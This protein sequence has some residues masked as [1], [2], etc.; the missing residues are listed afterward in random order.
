MSFLDHHL[1]S[2]NS[3]IGSSIA[4]LDSVLYDRIF[5]VPYDPVKLALRDVLLVS[6]LA[7]ATPAEVH[8]SAELYAVVRRRL[9]GFRI[10]LDVLVAPHF[11]I[12][13]KSTLLTEGKELS[14]DSRETFLN[15]LRPADRKLV[16]QVEELSS[17]RRFFHWDLEFPELFFAPRAGVLD[18]GGQSD[19]SQGIERK[20]TGEAG[21][22]A[23]VGNPP[24]VRQETIKLDK[25]YL[26]SAFA[27]TFD[28]AIDPLAIAASEKDQLTVIPGDFK[29]AFDGQLEFHPKQKRFLLLYNNKYDRGLAPGQHHPRTRFSISHELGHFYLDRHNSYLR[30]TR[31]K[32]G[33]RSEFA[34]NTLVEREADSFASGLLMP[35]LLMD[36][37]VNQCELSLDRIEELARTFQTSL[38]STALRAV[39]LSDYPCAVVGIRNGAVAWVSRSEA[40]IKN[41]F[42]PPR[43]GYFTSPVAIQQWQAF[44]MGV[45][46]R[47]K[48]PVYAHHWFET[49][50]SAELA[51]ISVTE[52]YLPVGSMSTLVVLLT[53]PEDELARITDYDD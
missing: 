20:P 41:R 22:D 32:H 8:Q 50:E 39:A 42:Y 48:A 45:M 15:S 11:G 23:I 7:D 52:H 47:H 17:Q 38:V 35:R 13:L 28:S 9:S 31:K 5:K 21:F 6:R 30:R 16:E 53:I 43:R 27:A 44:S 26:K 19:Y 40:L 29:N 33:S 34:N 36:G 18:V 24:Y 1:H 4:E 46:E 14:L 3:L 49:Y 37:E 2:G 12:P 51:T 10:V 25:V